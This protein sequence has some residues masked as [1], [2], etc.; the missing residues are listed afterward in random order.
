MSY[1]L[2]IGQTFPEPLCGD[3]AR[4]PLGV[5]LGQGGPANGR[6]AFF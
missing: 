6:P 5:S 4:L 3:A 2:K 1:V